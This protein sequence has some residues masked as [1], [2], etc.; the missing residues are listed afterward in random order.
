MWGSHF[1]AGAHSGR[2]GVAQAEW[3]VRELPQWQPVPGGGWA[4]VDHHLAEHHR[5]QLPPPVRHSCR[6]HV[7]IAPLH[8]LRAVEVQA[9]VEEGVVG[10]GD[11]AALG[12]GGEGGE[13]QPRLVRHVDGEALQVKHIVRVGSDLVCK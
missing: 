11:H 13:V 8:R 1:L 6:L 9:G 10:A 12:L 3:M 7:H 5:E 2:A 4:S